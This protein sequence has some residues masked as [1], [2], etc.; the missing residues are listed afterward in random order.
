MT[1]MEMVQWIFSSFNGQRD[2]NEAVADIPATPP[3]TPLHLKKPVESIDGLTNL[4]GDLGLSEE[5]RAEISTPRG[6]S[7]G[8][9]TPQG[10]RQEP[11]SNTVSP[12]NS[13]PSTP[14][15]SESPAKKTPAQD[16][17]KPSPSP[18]IEG[19]STPAALKVTDVSV[20]PADGLDSIDNATTGVVQ[21]G[22]DTDDFQEDD[23]KGKTIGAYGKTS[24]DGSQAGDG[25][26][27]RVFVNAQGITFSR[28]S[29]FEGLFLTLCGLTDF[30]EPKTVL[31]L[32]PC[33]VTFFL[34]WTR[35]RCAQ[36]R[37]H[38]NVRP[39]AH[40]HRCRD[41]RVVHHQESKTLRVCKGRLV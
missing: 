21:A 10:E 22:G 34:L 28:Q 36:D 23:T 1:L 37:I 17:D 20:S 8:Y 39:H 16:Q 31:L 4:V 13:T 32:R 7:G 24:L 33:E 12:R 3:N 41:S 6:V 26:E 5:S 14:T 11:G 35:K 2:L 29:D 15:R 19:P 30:R 25:D 40:Q 27:K 38:E 18:V 9:N